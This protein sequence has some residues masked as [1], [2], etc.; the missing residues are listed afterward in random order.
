V[1]SGEASA[2]YRLRPTTRPWSH[3]RI[4]GPTLRVVAAEATVGSDLLPRMTD[5]D[6][7]SRWDGRR[8][9]K[10]GDRVTLDLGSPRGVR[11]LELAIGGY[12][13][14]FP[15]RLKIETSLDGGAW[16]ER[17]TGS[18]GGAALAGALLDARRMPLF[19]ELDPRPARFI[20]LTQLGSDPVFYW[21]IAELT[22]FGS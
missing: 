20:R 4:D 22:V 2:S 13:A 14:D 19:F 18:G 11:G 12:I 9:Q 1:L 16:E 8:G 3:K 21:T 6:L 5:G 7:I 17:W 10:P 15:R